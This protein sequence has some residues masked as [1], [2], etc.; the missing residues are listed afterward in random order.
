MKINPINQIFTNFGKKRK[1]EQKEE[2]REGFK[3]IMDKMKK[4]SK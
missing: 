2:C 4:D 3:E 1:K